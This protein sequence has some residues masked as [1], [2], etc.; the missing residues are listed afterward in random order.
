MVD[1]AKKAPPSDT[2][3]PV[4]VG[5]WSLDATTTYV[6][7]ERCA[8]T[9]KRP[10]HLKPFRDLAFAVALRDSASLTEGQ[11][12]SATREWTAFG[13]STLAEH[14]VANSLA[15]KIQAD[16]IQ[17][18][19]DTLLE[20]A[21]RS[22][23]TSRGSSESDPQSRLV[24]ALNPD[25]RLAS[26]LG[27]V[28]KSM[29]VG[30]EIQDRSV[31]AR[32]TLLRKLG[33]G[34][35][36][37][38]WL[39]RDEN[40]NRYVAVKEL[41]S[42]AR[43]G[44]IALEHFRREAEVTGRL[45]HPGIV[46]IYQ[47]GCDEKTGKAFYAMRFLGRR[48]LQDAIDEY[49]ER[50][51]NGA[52]DKMLLH[53]LLSSFVSVCHSVEHAHSLRVIHRD[54][55]PA[56]VALDEFGQVTLLD[57]GLSK[58]NE[59]TGIYNVDGRSEPGDLHDMRSG[60]GGRV[61]GTPLY[62]APEQAA[63]RLEDVDTLTD[64]YGLGGILYA[65]LTG[66]G[67]HQAV[68]QSTDS[69][70]GRE[71][72]LTRIVADDVVPPH[73]RKNGVPPELDAICSKALSRQRYRRY[74]SAVEL[75][76]EVQRYMAGAPVEAYEAPLK[77]RFSRW[78]ERHPTLAQ[79]AM[80]SASLVLIACIAVG[81]TARAGQQRFVAARHASAIETA[82]DL[83]VNV[84]FEAHAL[85]RDLHFVTD[86]PLMSAITESHSADINVV[87]GDS[88]ETPIVVAAKPQG[89]PA[90]T[91]DWLDR[92]GNLFDGFLDANPAYLMMVSCK[93][94]ENNELRELVRSERV[95]AGQ[96]AMRVPDLQLR[97][98]SSDDGSQ[99]DFFELL[100]PGAAFLITNDQL[101]D[102]IPTNHRSPLVL[103]GVSAVYDARGGFFGINA[104]ELDLR[105]RL[106][107]LLPAIAPEYVNVYITDAEGFIEMDFRRGRFV[108]VQGE[109]LVTEEFPAL[110]SLF[111][112]ASSVTELG[113]DRKFYAKRVE[114]G[115]LSSH[116]QIG[117]VTYVTSERD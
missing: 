79:M 36:G 9:A 103:S 40:L 26:L 71:Q 101:S 15:D 88:T 94:E 111:D 112:P 63:G 98:S 22:A 25:G 20:Q 93:R 92:Q 4:S 34:G 60:Y 6:P 64:V 51:Q 37:T 18:A 76:E 104:I 46:P 74:Q 102:D 31:G 100:R 86:L 48:T 68:Q 52:E 41:T 14:L 43:S 83:E 80:L 66:V 5:E 81:L 106:Q 99:S 115:Q 77:R 95:S 44:E 116:A 53:R 55:K 39:A 1:S 42:E 84:L 59:V 30:E 2:A 33:Q 70:M 108:E 72:F 78:M 8:E 29:L 58:V 17:K 35:L 49:H 96:R 54:L 38:V 28:G 13:D 45:E 69:V 90:S 109:L 11:L 85:E 62:M 73:G 75:A 16:E 65:I 10:S 82:H 117:I 107:S 113:D 61:I 21:S 105:E 57:W 50:L 91:E 67:P 19:A 89:T 97:T 7:P 24:A 32:Y 23:S 110:Q 114:L 87:S 12:A 3:A 47:F 56:N 27:L